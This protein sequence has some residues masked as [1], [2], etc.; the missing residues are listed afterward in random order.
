AGNDDIYVQPLDGGV[1]R[2]LTTSP[3]RD[4]AP[5]W[6]PDGREVA[7]VRHFSGSAIVMTIPAF[8]GAERMLGPTT[9]NHVAWAP[10]GSGIAWLERQGIGLTPVAGGSRQRLTTS[11]GD[12]T[13][14]FA[15]DGKSL[16]VARWNTKDTS[17][18]FV[19]PL[20]GGDPR[21]LTYAGRP[22]Y[23]LVWTANGSEIVFSSLRPDGEGLWRVEAKGGSRARAIGTG[24][25]MRY[26]SLARGTRL[27]CERDIADS[28]VWKLDAGRSARRVVE[29]RGSDYSPDLSPSGHRMAFVSDRDG[30]PEIWLADP[31]GTRAMQLTTLRAS[32][33]GSPRFSPDGLRVAFDAVVEDEREIW[34]IGVDG[35]KP[36]RVA[37]GN[38]PAWSHDGRHIY[39]H[40]AGRIF[41]ASTESGEDAVAVTD[42]GSIEAAESWDGAVLYVLREKGRAGA[43][44]WSRP[45]G[46]GPMTEV[47]ASVERGWWALTDEGIYFAD[48]RTIHFYA[49][50]TRRT[51][52]V[53]ALP[54]RAVIG[55]PALSATRDGR[56]LMWHQDDAVHSDL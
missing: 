16:A 56:T 8:G 49:F 22:V 33:L 40:S 6:S 38:R 53:A 13:F 3:A 11:P 55:R 10:D 42:P 30:S 36:R 23:G 50:E 28:S 48:V 47:L 12:R 15:P 17:D 1:P 46:G 4:D 19:V 41:K 18:V 21:Q 44:L 14:S 32:A 31:D 54:S 37:T 2:R 9:G 5:A 45:A 27:A 24:G 51:R 39:C 43:S 29:S 25:D 7:F 20:D 35:G 34:A 26:P 52:R